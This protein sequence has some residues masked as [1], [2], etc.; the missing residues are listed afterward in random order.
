MKK[1]AIALFTAILIAGQFFTP[2]AAAAPSA[3]SAS[4]SCGDT[5]IVH[6]GDWLAK[7][8]N[9]CGTTVGSILAHN[10]QIFNP[11]WIY[12]GMVL[13]LTGSAQQPKRPANPQPRY[14]SSAYTWQGWGYNGYYQWQGWNH[15]YSRPTQYARVSLST[16]R[17]GVGDEVTVYASGFPANANIDF[18][19]GRQGKDYSL[20]YDGKT[21]SAGAAS[22]AFTI[23]S[24]ADEGQDWVVRVLTTELVDGVDLYSPAI[25][26]TN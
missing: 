6:R 18:R 3:W 11:N 20:V 26:I 17:A 8:A 10:P 22:Q 4:A 12:A 24:K 16:T 7:I 21:N 9:Y 23:P 5:Y 15:P 2:V 14:A 25:H 13:R 1:I 19:I